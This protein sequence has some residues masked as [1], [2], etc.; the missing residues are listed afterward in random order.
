VIC[1]HNGLVLILPNKV[2]I[3]YNSDTLFAHYHSQGPGLC[4]IRMSNG[5]VLDFVLFFITQFVFSRAFHFLKF[6]DCGN[7]GILDRVL[8]CLSSLSDS[9]FFVWLSFEWVVD[10]IRQYE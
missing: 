1:T 4:P 7:E 5:S 3:Y 10:G 2:I 6:E 9:V 8:I